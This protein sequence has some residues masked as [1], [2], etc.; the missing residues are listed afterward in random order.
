MSKH[1]PKESMFSAHAFVTQSTL[2]TKNTVVNVTDTI[3]KATISL[4]TFFKNFL[5]FR[6]FL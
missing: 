1:N 5:P 2:L 4:E 3:E 6:V